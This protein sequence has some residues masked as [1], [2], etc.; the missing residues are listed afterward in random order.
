MDTGSVKGAPAS[1]VKVTATCYGD[2][3]IPHIVLEGLQK[4]ESPAERKQSTIKGQKVV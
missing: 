1:S 3:S 2:K 4:T